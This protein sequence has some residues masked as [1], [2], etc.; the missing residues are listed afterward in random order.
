MKPILK[1]I[2][3]AAGAALI[4]AGC[5][6]G[7]GGQRGGG[8]FGGGGGGGGDGGSSAGMVLKK[9]DADG[10]GRIS[11]G[12]WQ[13]SPATF[14]AMDSDGD[15]ALSMRE[16]AA[17]FGGG[18]S[19]AQGGEGRTGRKGNKDRMSRQQMGGSAAAAVA[20]PIAAAPGQW[21]G[22]GW[23]GPIID[24]HSQIDEKTDLDG[25]IE[26]MNKAG[27]VQ[28]I[29]SA[30]FKQPSED[31][32]GLAKRYS[33]RIIPAAKSKTRAFTKGDG[34][35]P[36][37][38]AREF[39]KYDYRAIA[40]L[41]LWHAAKQSVGA[42][43]AAIEPDDP[44]LT[45]F[46]D[47]ARSKGFPL[48]L[49]FEFA[50]MGGSERDRYMAKMETFAA[51]NR[52]VPVG[53][54]HMGQLG[55]DEAARLLP[56]HPN[57]FFITSH[58]NPVSTDESRL[59]WTK[60]FSGS[61]LAPAW[62]ALVLRHPD[63]FVLGFDNVFHFQWNDKFLP[64]VAYWRKALAGL[65]DAIAHKV[66]HGNAERLW[67]LKPAAMADKVAAAK[68]PAPLDPRQNPLHPEA[69]REVHERSGVFET[70]V[71]ARYPRE[72]RCAEVKSPFGSQTRYDG[73][74]RA[75]RAYH[76]YHTGFDISLGEGTPLAALA[77]GEVVHKFVGGRLVG[78]QIFL[79]HAPEDT[80]LPVWLYSKYKHFKTLPTLKLGERVKMGQ[81]VGYSG[82]TGTVGGHY[83]PRGYPHLHLSVYMSRSGEYRANERTILPD[84]VQQIDPMAIYLMKARQ[85][86]DNHAIRALPAAQKTVAIPFKTT[87]G[88]VSPAATRLIW[89][90]LC[91]P[92]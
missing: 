28:A 68:P 77:D 78:N 23:K 45:P 24:V 51:A 67:K 65:P 88:G 17:R 69:S 14:D 64:A 47:L 11:R 15:G 61:T 18:A 1:S 79:R 48:V 4:L 58:S 22:A 56:K 60:M 39:K 49:H 55:T 46:L 86:F 74:V 33:G 12:E 32:I 92:K 20:A 53:L 62:R 44:R 90:V 40:E 9:N 84:Q 16:L 10:D 71:T 25:V 26:K 54:I 66:A 85:V 75:R 3:F 57:L 27:V 82:K 21:T 19:K 89:P 8:K 80:G 73:S 29:L 43:K 5:Q 81:V 34:W 63:R 35:S 87:G 91:E 50:A 59:P 37:I 36:D 13:K 70:G 30:R 2:L 6:A 83:G 72:A 52:D 7:G 76:S 38:A 41:I 31:V 42:G